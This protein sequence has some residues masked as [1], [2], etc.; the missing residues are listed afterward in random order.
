M[1]SLSDHLVQ[2]S[3]MAMIVWGAQAFARRAHRRRVSREARRLRSALHIGLSALRK[4]YEDNL[5]GPSAS[6]NNQAHSTRTR[7]RISPA[8]LNKRRTAVS[9]AA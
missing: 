6:A 3:C 8:S 2:L 7:S 4:L 5:A 1:W 9:L